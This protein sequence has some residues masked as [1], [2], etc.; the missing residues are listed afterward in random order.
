M[1][2]SK[3]SIE[4]F[5]RTAMALVKVIQEDAQ[6]IDDLRASNAHLIEGANKTW[7]QIEQ[8]ILKNKELQNKI[9]RILDLC[10]REEAVAAEFHYGPEDADVDVSD[11]R[12]ILAA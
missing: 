4:A 2:D 12:E 5:D 6:I 11:I 3:V 7:K 1:N 8:E 9:E 10:E